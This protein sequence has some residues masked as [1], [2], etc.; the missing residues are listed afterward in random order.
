MPVVNVGNARNLF[1]ALK[2]SLTEK[3]LDFSKAVA[4]ILSDTTNVMKGAR[5]GVQKLIRL[6]TVVNL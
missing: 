5:S 6:E 3:G 4:L 1:D 2:L